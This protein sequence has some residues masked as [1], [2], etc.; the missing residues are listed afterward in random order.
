MRE[1]APMRVL[2]RPYADPGWINKIARM[3]WI[4]EFTGVSH[5]GGPEVFAW[6]LTDRARSG[7][8]HMKITSYVARRWDE[9]NSRNAN[10]QR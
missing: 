3:I 6:Y 9:R 10:H 8:S 2:L 1:L 4:L 7:D 5:F